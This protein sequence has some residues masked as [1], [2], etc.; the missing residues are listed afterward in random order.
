MKQIGKE[1]EIIIRQRGILKNSLAKELGITP[2]WL[3]KLFQ[4]NS[5]DCALLDKICG[6]IGISPAYFF[7]IDMEPMGGHVDAMQ[8]DALKREVEVL[9]ELAR[10]KE[11]TIQ[12]LLKQTGQNRDKWN[13]F[14]AQIYRKESVWK[15][16]D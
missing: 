7:D 12:I 9:R 3:S 4:K 14:I 11:R 10:D 8:A 1:L 5:I 6:I 2:T 15:S 13:H 16:N